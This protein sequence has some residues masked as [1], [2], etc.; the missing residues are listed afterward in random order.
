MIDFPFLSDL[1]ES[2]LI[3][4]RVALKKWKTTKLAELCYLYFVALCVLLAESKT[5]AWARKYCTKAGEPNDFN[6]WRTNANDLYAML[7]A[8]GSD[9]TDGDTIKLSPSIIRHWLRHVATSDDA[10]DTHRLLLRLDGMFHISSSAIKALRRNVTVW[11]DADKTERHDVTIK[12]AQLIHDRA[13]SNS[14]ILPHLKRLI[15][16]MHESASSGATGVASI[17]TVVGG[18]GAGFD[19]K[20]DRGIYQK[21]KPVLIRRGAVPRQKHEQ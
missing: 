3:P 9:E 13:P 6:T 14:E 16:D 4:S 1:C 10:E 15:S 5:K 12:L 11:D 7:Y 18:L 8:L 2:Q 19:P 17:A 21:K 20:G